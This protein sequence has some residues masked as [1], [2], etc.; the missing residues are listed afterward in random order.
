MCMIKKENPKLTVLKDLLKKPQFFCPFYK[1]E[2]RDKRARIL[3][4]IEECN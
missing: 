2:D 1:R 4:R 3:K